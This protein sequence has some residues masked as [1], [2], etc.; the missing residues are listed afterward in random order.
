[1]EKTLGATW[2]ALA[3]GGL[4]VI[5]RVVCQSTSAAEP[6]RKLNAVKVKL[7]VT[8]EVVNQ[9]KRRVEGDNRFVIPLHE[10][11]PLLWTVDQGT[12]P[13]S[14]IKRWVAGVVEEETRGT[15]TGHPC[16]WRRAANPCTGSG[17]S[18]RM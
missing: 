16:R 9:I 7:L 8:P 2:Q 18:R 4:A 14:K 13:E 6:M 10:G 5:R 12:P 17:A 15:M 1:M 11:Q 3:D